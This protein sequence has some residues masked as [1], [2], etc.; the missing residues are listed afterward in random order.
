MEDITRVI[1]I[2]M[3]QSKKQIVTSREVQTAVRILY[4]PA[5]E[6]VSEGTHL[7]TTYNMSC[8][9]GTQDV[10]ISQFDM[11]TIRSVRQIFKDELKK[12]DTRYKCGE[13]APIYLFGVLKKLSEGYVVNKIIETPE[14]DLIR[15][16][17][18]ISGH[19][20]R[21]VIRQIDLILACKIKYPDIEFKQYT[22]ERNSGAPSLY[23]LK[24]RVRN[25]MKK[26]SPDY[27]HQLEKNALK[28]WQ[29]LML[30]LKTIPNIANTQVV[31]TK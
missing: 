3:Q 18:Y 27:Q 26:Y 24:Y 8:V 21:S 10:Y 28:Y 22:G 2:L 20:R 15:I 25:I 11:E 23:S 19:L 29:F 31:A 5:N 13:G 14:D 4:N 30:Q 9:N 1:H 7:V 12:Y 17:Y 6:L 16:A